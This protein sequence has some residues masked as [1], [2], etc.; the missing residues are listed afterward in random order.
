MADRHIMASPHPAPRIGLKSQQRIHGL[1]DL[2]WTLVR[3]GVSGGTA[4]TAHLAVLY[5]LVDYGGMHPVLATTFAFSVST[6]INFLLQQH[7]VFN[8]PSHRMR[9]LMRY[10]GVTA[11][12][13]MLNAV[14]FWILLEVTTIPY[15]IVQIGVLAVIAIF[16]FVANKL[17]TFAEVAPVP[18]SAAETGELGEQGAR[19]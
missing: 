8:A 2:A 4:V 19:S 7:F 18:E 10:I 16:N 11:F 17:Y 5:L 15:L 14:L 12:S 9:R 13:A 6:P 1:I 3:Y